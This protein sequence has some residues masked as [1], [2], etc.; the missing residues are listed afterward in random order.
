MGDNEPKKDSD[1]RSL[2]TCRFAQQWQAHLKSLYKEYQ[3]RQLCVYGAK[4]QFEA[5]HRKA[6][7]QAL[8]DSSNA[9]HSKKDHKAI[10]EAV[11]AE[12]TSNGAPR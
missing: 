12:L 1:R 9:V 7:V 11:S 8:V 2:E 4:T 5:T 10:K 3:K 6:C